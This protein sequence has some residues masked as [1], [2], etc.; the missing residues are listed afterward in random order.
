MRALRGFWVLSTL[1]ACR[2]AGPTT[3]LDLLRAPCRLFFATSAVMF[4]AGKT[5]Y[6]LG[7]VGLLVGP[8]MR[9]Q[10]EQQGL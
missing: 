3:M 4:E 2:P 7:P 10:A 5:I 8:Q 1:H 6:R 9:W